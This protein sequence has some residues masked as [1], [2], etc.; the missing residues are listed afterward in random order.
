[1]PRQPTELIGPAEAVDFKYK[2]ATVWPFTAGLALGLLVGIG[3]AVAWLAR[4]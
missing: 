1:M 2:P 4:L 3:A